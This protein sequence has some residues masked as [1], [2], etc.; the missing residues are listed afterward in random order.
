M[1]NFSL[2]QRTGNSHPL[3]HYIVMML[4]N[5]PFGE[6]H[7]EFVF[8]KTFVKYITQRPLATFS[9]LSYDL[10]YIFYKHTCMLFPQFD[11]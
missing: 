1:G 2:A 9:Y 11:W 8:K 3:M 10:D 5:K 4:T 6:W 7:G